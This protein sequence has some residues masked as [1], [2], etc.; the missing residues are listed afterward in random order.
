MS[1][2]EIVWIKDTS[3]IPG[4][5]GY[6]YRNYISNDGRF[7]I[8]HNKNS[9]T[10]LWELYDHKNDKPWSGDWKTLNLAKNEAYRIQRMES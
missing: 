7:K 9:V 4:M 1:K 5:P 6:V 10:N 2:L 8:V 3:P